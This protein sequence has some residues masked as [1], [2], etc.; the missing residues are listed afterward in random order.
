ML[1][2]IIGVVGSGTMGR[3]IAQAFL[4]AGYEVIITDKDVNAVQ[5]AKEYIIK[6]IDKVV[7]LEKITEEE[8]KNYKKNI[9]CTNGLDGLTA[10]SVIIE[11]VN[12]DLVLKQEL[13]G[14][15]DSMAN[16]ET[17]LASNTSTLSI[18]DIAQK[19]G[20]RKRVIGIHFFVPAEKMKLVEVIP[21]PETSGENISKTINLLNG[22]G[23]SPVLCKDT[24]GFIVNRLFLL[25]E[26][27][28]ARMFEEEVASMEDIDNAIK[29]GLNHKMGPLE[30]ADLV[31]IDVI[32]HALESLYEATKDPKFKPAEILSRMVINNELGQKTGR[33]FYK[34]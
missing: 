14:K 10:A 25:F 27:E 29:L 21:G 18:E 12:E 30:L 9:T 28:A 34:Y 5:S 7:E 16:K 33:G 26:N 24:P 13:F 3:G 31:G 23:K 8:G 2:D 20:N 4:Q 32:F 19:A 15:L 22:I 6:G 1:K 17:I 11:A